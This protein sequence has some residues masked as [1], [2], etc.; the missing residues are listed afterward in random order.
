MS[1]DH[2]YKLL[3]YKLFAK[4]DKG[5][6]IHSPFVFNMIREVFIDKTHYPEYKQIEQ[7]RQSL[8]QNNTILQISDYGAGSK[9][10]N[11]SENRKVKDIANHSLKSKKYGQLIFRLARYFESLVIIELGT[12][13]GVTTQYLAAANI[14]SGITTIEGCPQI[15]EFNK[16]SIPDADKEN[17]VFRCGKFDDILT[18]I[19]S[20]HASVDLVFFDGNHRKEPTLKYFKQCLKKTNDNSIFIFDD[21]YWS[22]EMESAWNEIKANPE[23]S[24]T[25]DLFEL[26]LV[27]FRKGIEKQDFVVKF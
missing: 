24:I 21:I 23:V 3:K 5:F 17:I 6:G 19:L 16:N 12:S 11:T 8:K 26:G 9:R 4:H 10:N 27:F 14:G 2:R 20:E 25:V 18:D 1:H 22:E 7:Y 13:L 15:N